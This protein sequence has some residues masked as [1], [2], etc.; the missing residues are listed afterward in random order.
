MQGHTTNVN[1]ASDKSLGEYVPSPVQR[2]E[3][4]ED[5]LTRLIEQQSAKLPSQFFLFS[6]FGAMA[7]SLTLELSGRTRASRFI[8]MW[9]PAL[10]TMGIYNKL[11]KILGSR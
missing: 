2:D 7:A 11:V 9:P 1:P 4:S 8:G 3:L 6:A 5:V 10:L